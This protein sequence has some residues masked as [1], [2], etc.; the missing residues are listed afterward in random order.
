MMVTRF[1][2]LLLF[3]AGMV[4]VAQVPLPASPSWTSQDN[5]YSTGGAFADVNGDGRLDLCTSNGNDMAQNYNGIYLNRGDS[6]ERVA[7]WRSADRGYFGHCYAGDVDNDGDLDLAVAYLGPTGDLR[8]R[9]YRDTG[10]GLETSPCWKA[11][12]QHSSFDCCLGDVDLDGDLDLAIS[13]GD[14]YSGEIDSARIYR[15]NAGVFDS[16]PFWTARDGAASD[17]VRFCDVDDDGDL[18]LFVG[19]RNRITMYRNNAGVLDPNP[20]WVAR[21]NVGWVLRLEPGDYDGD[22]L[23]DLAV[24]C[25]DQL[26][27]PNGVRV[28]HNT[29]GTLDT[30]PVFTMWSSADYTSCVAWADIDGDGDLDLAAGGWWQPVVVFRND[31]GV[32]GA[33]PAWSWQD[34]QNLVCEAIVFGDIRN[35]HLASGSATWDGDG[36]R[37]LF[38]IPHRPA[39]T[40]SRVIVNDSLVPRS[41]YCCDPLA[42]W[43]SLTAAP[44]P[45]ND[46]VRIE[47]RYSTHPDLC[48]TNWVASYGNHLFLNTTPVGVAA[49]PDPERVLLSVVPN[50]AAGPMRF[51]LPGATRIEIHDGSGRLVRRF[52]V[53]NG[54]AVWDGCDDAGRPVRSGIYFG[55]A[56]SDVVKLIRT[57]R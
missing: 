49:N 3:A 51:R 41:D 32:I 25:N 8:V 53:S 18:D 14:A 29:G 17:A 44:P 5:D 26:G 31:A 27:D 46:N 2:M 45:G 12:D 24:A 57:A 36:S 1:A 7:S 9:V 48:V 50:P 6:L 16:L 15:N 34:G 11:R 13:A 19:H 10:A 20:A 35:A 28:Y 38:A 23:P 21:R 40:I 22:G 30:I 54:Q 39:H 55:S 43:V 37:R 33:T 47:Y 4:A 52:A 42:G 56:G